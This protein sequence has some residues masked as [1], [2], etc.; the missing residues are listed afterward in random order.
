M[1]NIITV[2]HSVVNHSLSLTRRYNLYHR[3]CTMLVANV[4]ISDPLPGTT[5]T[6]LSEDVM[7]FVHIRMQGHD[8][9]SAR[10]NKE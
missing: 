4:I 7:D 2:Y 8:I 9:S 3:M 10:S 1:S 6:S 5:G